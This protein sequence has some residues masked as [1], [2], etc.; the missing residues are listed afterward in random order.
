MTKEGAT[1]LCTNVRPFWGMPPLISNTGHTASRSCQATTNSWLVSIFQTAV[2]LNRRFV[3]KQR[4]ADSCRVKKYWEKSTNRLL[5]HPA[6]SMQRCKYVEVHRSGERTPSAPRRAQQEVVNWRNNVKVK[7]RKSSGN[8]FLH[9]YITTN[10]AS[11]HEWN[12]TLNVCNASTLDN[13][14]EHTTP[15]SCEWEQ[16]LPV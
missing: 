1:Y 10:Y 3:R 13:S 11:E 8:L 14:R 12:E 16:A 7:P 9:M 5:D 4:K 6:F 2:V 15:A